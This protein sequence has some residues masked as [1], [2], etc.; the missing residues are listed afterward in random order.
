MLC[1]VLPT[2][3]QIPEVIKMWITVHQVPCVKCCLLSVRSWQ[4]SRCE[5]SVAYCLSDPRWELESPASRRHWPQQRWGAG[6]S[7]WPCHWGCH[8]RSC[9]CALHLHPRWGSSAAR[10]AWRWLCATARRWLGAQSAPTAA[11]HHQGHTAPEHALQRSDDTTPVARETQQ[12]NMPLADQNT[13]SVCLL[14]GNSM[15][16]PHMTYDQ[17][18]VLSLSLSS[19]LSLNREGCWAPR[20]R[21]AEWQTK[22]FSRRKDWIHNLMMHST[23]GLL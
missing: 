18:R 7:S 19:H 8:G 11:H 23:G 15:T 12:F 10:R 1:K 5:L 6:W 2:V 20:E 13:K 17:E 21:V 3:C 14:T 22:A 9:S 16:R 4:W